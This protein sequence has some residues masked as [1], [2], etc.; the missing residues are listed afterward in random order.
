MS[1]FWNQRYAADEYAYG[2]RPNLFFKEQ[3]EKL[4]PGSVLFAAEG[5]GRNAVFAAQLGW[6]VTAFDLST[7]G[8]RKAGNLASGN[9]VNISYLV[10]G[11][12]DVSFEPESFDCIVLVFAHMPAEKREEY[13]RRLMSFLKLGGTMILEGFSK[14]QINFNSGGPRDLKML[15]SKAE[16]ESDFNQLSDL[17]IEEEEIELDEGPFHQGKA[18]VIRLIGKK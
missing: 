2:T 11:Y 3:I 14:E 12:E 7:E 6:S 18:A 10:A 5:E 4:Q 13:H 8:K 15:F 17:N 1:E 9:G 16:L